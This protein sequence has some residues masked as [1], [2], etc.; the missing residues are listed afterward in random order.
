[1]HLVVICR[2]EIKRLRQTL[3]SA[4]P[5]I[6]SWTILDTGSTDGTQS[7]AFKVLEGV[8]GQLVSTIWPDSFARARNWAFEHAR[9]YVCQESNPYLLVLDAGEQIGTD[10][11]IH[12]LTADAYTVQVNYG[13]CEFPS[14]R[15]FRARTPWTW[16]YRVHETAEGGS[17][18]EALPGVEVFSDAGD[19][20]AEKYAA[21]ARLS[22]LDLVDYPDDPRV[23]FYAAQNWYAAGEF[24]NALDRYALRS[25]MGGYAEEVWYSAMRQGMCFERMG[26][27]EAA[28][29]C[30]IEA[31]EMNP[32][33]AE[34]ARHLARMLGSANWTQVAD[35]IPCPA[36]GLF[37]ERDAYA[38]ITRPDTP[39]ARAAEP[40]SGPLDWTFDR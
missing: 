7:L 39:Q 35:A 5:L 15:V 36:S 24:R 32:G 14:T 30:Y 9:A 31:H 25:S 17:T 23:V 37:V 27:R 19:C 38:E 40:G 22:E 21:Y 28:A 12:D 1:M 3:E 16:R 33:R 34:P 29:Q 2:N 10:G 11:R 6:D 20:S 4:L 8:P 18:V 26:D 13:A